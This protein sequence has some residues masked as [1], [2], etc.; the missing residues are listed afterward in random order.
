MILQSPPPDAL[1]TPIAI[2]VTI[3]GLA[4]LLPPL[5]AAL[6]RR[7]RRRPRTPRT[8]EITRPRGGRSYDRPGDEP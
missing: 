3:A 4:L 8:T 2:L 1:P 6:V 5:I 7:W